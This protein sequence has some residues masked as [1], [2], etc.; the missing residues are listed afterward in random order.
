MKSRQF[1]LAYVAPTLLILLW[2]VLPLVR[3]THT[4]YLRD[5]LNAHLQKKLVQVEAMEQGYLP[6]VDA[7]RDLSLIHI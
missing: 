5:V 1:L 6:L 2:A 4:L 3:G 7:L